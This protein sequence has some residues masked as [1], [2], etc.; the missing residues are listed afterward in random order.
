[1]S[2]TERGRGGQLR[3]PRLL[4]RRWRESD[5]E[6]L[7]AINADPEVMEFF[8]S[9]L[10]RAQSAAQIEESERSFEARGYGRWAV[11]LCG[12]SRLVGRVGA[13]SVDEDLPFSPGVE[14]GWSLAR[15]VWGRGIATEAAIAACEHAF[16]TL[17]LEELLAYAAA[18]NLRSQRVMER[19]GM[20]RDPAEDFLHPQLSIEDPLAPHQLHRL[21]PG[22]LASLSHHDVRRD[23]PPPP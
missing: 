15:E 18:R 3:T 7:S 14:L 10:T 6:P 17:G 21:R 8:P 5:I 12:E 13:L 22:W 11:E 2:E 23:A 1:M 4:L 19:L 20:R 16:Q 9:T